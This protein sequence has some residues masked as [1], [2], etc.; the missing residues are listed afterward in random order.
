MSQI[1]LTTVITV[2]IVTLCILLG[3][4]YLYESYYVKNDLQ[5]EIGRIVPAGKIRIAKDEDPPAVYIRSAEIENLQT[6]YLNTEKI[7]RRQLGPGYKII[8]IDE[9]TPEI[10]SLYEK[11]GFIIQE[12]IATG[13]FQEMDRRVGDLARTAGIRSHLSIDSSN[14]YL[15]LHDDRGYLYEVI[16]RFP[17]HGQQNIMEKPGGEVL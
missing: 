12:A 3:G 5:E 17:G 11:C 9:R 8:F 1:R 13:G 10:E 4:Q 2:L 7:V 6:V 15:E 16:P 14:I